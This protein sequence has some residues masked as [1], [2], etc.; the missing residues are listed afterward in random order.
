MVSKI[1]THNLSAYYADT[2][3]ISTSTEHMYKYRNATQQHMHTYSQHTRNQHT[4][5]HNNHSVV[6]ATQDNGKLAAGMHMRACPQKI[7]HFTL[8][9]TQPMTIFQSLVHRWEAL[10]ILVFMNTYRLT[11]SL[12]SYGHVLI[13]INLN[14]E[15]I[16]AW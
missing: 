2:H 7:P 11:I 16:T 15:N 12:V 10:C 14:N 1:S 8:Q 9:S 3:R 5:L 13:A 4:H 6:L